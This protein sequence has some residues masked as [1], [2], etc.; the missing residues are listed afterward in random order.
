[1]KYPSGDKIEEIVGSQSMA[2]Q[3][4]VAAI[5]LRLEAESSASTEGG[6]WQSRIPVLSMDAVSEEAKCERLEEIAIDG[7]LKK[8]F[9]VGA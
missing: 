5:I 2:R 3:C 8:F 1:M 7:D 4:L 6:S 9:Q